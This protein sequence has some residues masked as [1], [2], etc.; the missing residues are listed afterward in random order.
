MKV[1]LKGLLLALFTFLVVLG[2]ILFINVDFSNSE[3]LDVFIQS[4][5]TKAEIPG[6]SCL[7]IRDGKV[8]SIHHVG[9]S[10]VEK[11]KEISD[12]TLFQVASVSKT[13]TGVA[14][15]QLYEK[16]L[17]GL[18]EDI[19]AYLPFDVIHPHFP[20]TPITF[21]MLLTHTSGI[22]N[23][24]NVYEEFYTLKTG[25]GDSSVTLK[26]FIQGFLVEGG[27][28]YDA[29]SN[30]LTQSPGEVYHYSNPSFA[31]LGYLVEVVADMD[32]DVY[33]QK[34]IFDP[35]G[36][37]TTQW[38]LGNTDLPRLAIPYDEKN[39]ALPNYSFASYPDG[40]LKTT[41]MEF[42]QFVLALLNDEEEVPHLLSKA[43]VNEM[44]YPQA[45]EGKQALVWSYSVLEDLLLPSSNGVV[46]GHSGSDPG[47]ATL[48]LINREKKNGLILFMNKEISINFKSI[49]IYLLIRRLIHEAGLK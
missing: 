15:M 3:S 7:L 19:N 25:G 47:I 5:I 33:C 21:R 43:I 34:Y 2:I 9:Y 44:F 28:W 26:D 16:G 27:E 49:N 36:M 35:L 39:I 46:A 22:A 8:V 32:F 31:L 38:F 41:A 24:W 13:V 6:A 48:V 20:D 30:F 42:A 45:R 18:D 29:D 14:L 37:D 17:I 4:K 1:F 11:K 10:N 40:A 23:N 12:D